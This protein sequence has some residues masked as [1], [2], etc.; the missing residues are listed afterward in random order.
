MMTRK[1]SNLPPADRQRRRILALPLLILP[2][3]CGLTFAAAQVA[4]RLS[5]TDRVEVEV[6]APETADY[7]PWEDATRFSPVDPRLGTLVAELSPDA[8]RAVVLLATTAAPAPEVIAATEV[9]ARLTDTAPTTIADDDNGD[10]G[11]ETPGQPTAEHEPSAQ[12][13]EATTASATAVSATPEPT[14]TA[15]PS[16]TPTADVTSTPPATSTS[17]P[18]VFVPSPT[19]F[20]PSPTPF[21]LPPPTFTPPPPTSTPLPPPPPTNTPR[22]PQTPAPTSALLPLTILPL[23]SPDPASYLVWQV[24]NENPQTIGFE[25]RIV[26]TPLT[27]AETAPPGLPGTPGTRIIT[28]DTQPA[29]DNRLRIRVNGQAQATADPVLAPCFTPTPTAT[30]TETATP[31]ETP[32]PTETATE[33]PTA[34]ATATETPTPTPTVALQTIIID[35]QDAASVVIIGDWVSSTNIAGYYGA[36]YLHDIND[37]KGN[38]SVR[39]TP[40]LAGGTYEVYARWAAAGNRASNTPYTIFA[41]NGTYVISVDQRVDGGIWRLLGTFTFNPGTAGSVQITT[42]A[43]D[44]FVIADAVR[45]VQIN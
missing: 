20:V 6:I 7:R 2:L 29:S 31:T 15:L 23:C 42:E 37:N 10:N 26:G 35:N 3:L 41:A 34:T 25:W 36:D 28:T 5:V 22:P 8:P 21:V 44:G 9:A 17:P 39:F 19:L 18:T 24:N 27:G 4:L 14:I 1:P 40:D 38:K 45:F 16:S 11:S 32:T 13:T 43:T 33:T 12:P 30:E